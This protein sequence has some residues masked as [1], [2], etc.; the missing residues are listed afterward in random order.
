MVFIKK[1][2]LSYFYFI[3]VIISL[4]ISIIRLHKLFGFKAKTKICFIEKVHQMKENIRVR[5]GNAGNNKID[6][7][8]REF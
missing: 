5:V 6:H 4:W 7:V 1:E 2:L 3:Y 8:S